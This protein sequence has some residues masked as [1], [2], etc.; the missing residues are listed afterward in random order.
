MNEISDLIDLSIEKLK[1]NERIA[2]KEQNDPEEAFNRTP[3]DHRIVFF[4]FSI[5]ELKKIAS[6]FNSKFYV[7]PDDLKNIDFGFEGGY[8]FMYIK[9]DIPEHKVHFTKEVIRYYAAMCDDII[10]NRKVFFI[11]AYE[12]TKD[13]S[14]YSSIQH[15]VDYRIRKEVK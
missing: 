10:K 13:F 3:Y 4:E 8:V 6:A 5:E 1:D 9:S 14:K 12:N 7:L 15:H 11:E 2:K